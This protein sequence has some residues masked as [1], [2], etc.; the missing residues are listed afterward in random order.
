MATFL[1]SA[2]QWYKKWST[3]LA[4]SSA[5]ST[6]ALGAY[7][8]LPGRVQGLIPDAALLPLGAIAVGSALLIPLATSLSQKSINPPSDG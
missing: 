8:I 3:W 1:P 6:A 4:I 5:S 2:S 7:A